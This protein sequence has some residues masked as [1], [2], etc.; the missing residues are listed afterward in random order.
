MSLRLR[1]A[2]LFAA[3]TAV[4]IAAAAVV[5]LW[6]LRAA[7][8]SAMDAGLRARGPALTPWRPRSARAAC[9]PCPPRAASRAVFRLK[10]PRR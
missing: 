3:A 2:L 6:Q 4:V 9:R 1:L 10:L 7:Q 8:I 5:S